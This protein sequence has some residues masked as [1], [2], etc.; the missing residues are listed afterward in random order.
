MITKRVEESLVLRLI[1]LGDRLK[2]RRD[3]ICQ[4]LGVSTQQWLLMLHVAHDPNLGG[5][6]LGGPN[7]PND[8]LRPPV[9]AS[10]LADALNVSRPNITNMIN[11][12]LEKGLVEQVE[13]PKDKRR[14]GLILSQ[15]GQTLLDALQPHRELLNSTL[16]EH[17]S[18][19]EKATFLNL[20][21]QCLADLDLPLPQPLPL[22][23]TAETA[24]I[25]S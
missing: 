6:N 1:A 10:E 11:S 4:Q 5:P 3:L 17:F 14:K 24:L 2:R 18:A 15:Q 12:L 16:F 9:L 23:A 8:S 20:A 7:V 22:V 21:E 19:A 13:D 25:E